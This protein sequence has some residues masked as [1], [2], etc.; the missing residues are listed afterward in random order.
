MTP[1]TAAQH[2]P[3]GRHRG[4]RTGLA[5]WLGAATVLGGSLVLLI[6]LLGTDGGDIGTTSYRAGYRAGKESGM[7]V[8]DTAEDAVAVG[9]ACS[10]LA[11]RSVPQGWY[12]GCSD[13]LTGSRPR[14]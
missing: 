9:R 14:R 7:Q 6:A 11:G 10:N 13:A 12:T 1:Q 4:P 8:G 3:G 2:G 5:A